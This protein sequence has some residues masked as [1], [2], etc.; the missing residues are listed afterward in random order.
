MENL[1]ASVRSDVF[2]DPDV[3]VDGDETLVFTSTL[4]NVSTNLST[5][6]LDL[7]VDYTVYTVATDS[8]GQVTGRIS[9]PA[10]FRIAAVPTINVTAPSGSETIDAGDPVHV[11]FVGQDSEGVATISILV[12]TDDDFGNGGADMVAEGLPITATS[13]DVDTRSFIAPTTKTPQPQDIKLLK[14]RASIRNGNGIGCHR[15]CVG[16]PIRSNW[17]KINR[18]PLCRLEP[19]RLFMLPLIWE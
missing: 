5:Q 16:Q 2:V 9:A 17:G 13:F 14:C 10:T 19:Y 6:G 4:K 15:Q 18:S 11:E 3:G 12:D 1:A 7:G 8:V